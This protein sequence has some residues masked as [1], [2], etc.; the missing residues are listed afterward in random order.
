MKDTFN[1]KAFLRTV[2]S[3]PG[4]YRMYDKS[5]TVIYVGKAKDLKK[6][7]TSYFRSN[8]PNVKT[9]ALVSHIA[10]IDVTVTH[11]ETDALILENDYIKQYMPKYNVLLRDDKSYPYILLSGHKHPR[12]AYH[13]G[14]KREKGQYFGP[15]PNGGAVR[16][17][18]HL[19]QKIFPI[20]QCEDIYYK[21]RSRPCLQYQIGRCSAPCV[22]KVSDEDYAAQVK[23]ASLFLKG[24]DQQV[25]GS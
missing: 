10:D 24:K 18:L 14:V 19:L 3:S 23:L 22:G 5:H 20:R 1:A 17:S 9:Q 16:E 2:T 15:Y 8:I 11:S 13:R 12:L 21:A 25:M 4:V 7:L 6:R